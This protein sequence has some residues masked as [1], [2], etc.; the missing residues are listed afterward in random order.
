MNKPAGEQVSPGQV[1]I[2]LQVHFCNKVMSGA[3]RAENLDVRTNWGLQNFLVERD[4]IS[5]VTFHQSQ[6]QVVAKLLEDDPN[7]LTPGCKC[8]IL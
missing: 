2:L 1:P 8:H 7:F 5:L 3:W 4:E 6:S